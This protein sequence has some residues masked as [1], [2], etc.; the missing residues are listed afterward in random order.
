[1][2]TLPVI[3]YF[4]YQIPVLA[5]ILNAIVVPLMTAVMMSVLAGVICGMC[6]AF[7]GSV[8]IAPAVYIMKI[9]ETLCTIN[10]KVPWA[11]YVTGKPSL[12]K[13]AVF[14]IMLAIICVIIYNTDK[15]KYCIAYIPVMLFLFIRPREGFETYF[16]SVGQGD[17]IFI[18]T[19]SG[20]T[21]LIDCGSS[22]NDS[23]YEYTIEPFLLSKKVPVLDYVIV[24]HMDNDHISGIKDLLTA[25]KIKVK[26][27]LIPS[28]ALIDEEYMDFYNMA[29]QKAGDVSLIYTGASYNFGATSIICVHPDY[30][31]ECEERNDY[32]T[33]LLVENNGF[34]MLL[35]GDILET[36]EKIV[37]ARLENVDKIHIYKA[38]HHGSK[39][40]NS[41]LL[42]DA[43]N[44]ENVV[45][46]CGKD[47]S[48]G[49]PHSEA[50]ERFEDADACI[51]RTDENGA[52]I[53]HN[54]NISVMLK[55]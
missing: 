21:I 4:Y 32:S 10:L 19:D 28:T 9:Y 41:K 6:N 11:V 16:L 31:Y 42:L 37:A 22:D 35:T 50:M 36:Q 12:I 1:M 15:R 55:D 27:I 33:V 26:N 5:V 3:M 38:A 39:Y 47:N 45:I 8:C 54:H 24:T 46:S 18:H 29:V 51:Y 48:Y 17:G 13:I 20:K 14:Y 49:H 44:P 53:V 43:I 25:G 7:L 2:S 23:L 52:I 34:T 40:S 30:G